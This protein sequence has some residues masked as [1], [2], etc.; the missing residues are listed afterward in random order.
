MRT[1]KDFQVGRKC[2]QGWVSITDH[3]DPGKTI[4]KESVHLQSYN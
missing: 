4:Q 2:S 3:Q 1:V